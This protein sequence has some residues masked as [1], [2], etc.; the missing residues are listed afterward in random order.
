[1]TDRSMRERVTLHEDIGAMEVD[2]TGLHFATN[3]EV[4]AFYDETDRRLAA[5]GKRWYFLVTYTDCV[6]APDLTLRQ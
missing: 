3:A 6:I 2:L 4:E 5:T 1:M